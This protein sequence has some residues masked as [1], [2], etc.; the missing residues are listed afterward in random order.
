MSYSEENFE[1]RY[2]KKISLVTSNKIFWVEKKAFFG[3]ENEKQEKKY[4]VVAWKVHQINT[5]T[6]YLLNSSFRY[7]SG[8]I[9]PKIGSLLKVATLKMNFFW[10]SLLKLKSKVLLNDAIWARWRKRVNWF[11]RIKLF[12]IVYRNSIIIV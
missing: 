2:E 8:H 9:W 4:Y 3:S 12:I 7:F 10:W 5:L 6:L 1:R 11:T